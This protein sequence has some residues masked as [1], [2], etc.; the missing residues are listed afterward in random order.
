[1]FR[2]QLQDPTIGKLSSG[3]I[4]DVH[5][6]GTDHHRPRPVRSVRSIEHLTPC[7]APAAHDNNNNTR[8]GGLVAL[9]KRTWATL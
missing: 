6:I 2:G 1:M 8:G 7:G 5:S 9:S 4:N 3:T